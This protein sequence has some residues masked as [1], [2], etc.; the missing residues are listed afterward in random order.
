[1]GKRGPGLVRRKG[2]MGSHSRKDEYMMAPEGRWN[3]GKQQKQKGK[4]F[5]KDE[6]QRFMQHVEDLGAR[7][8]IMESDGNCLFRALADQ[9]RGRPEDHGEIRQ[10]VIDFIEAHETDFAPF[11]EDDEKLSDYVHRMRNEGEWGAFVH[12]MIPAG[13]EILPSPFW[14]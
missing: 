8:L 7:I 3:G 5:D 9:L 14:L 13:W 6:E 2:N 1:M 11:V 4:R 10:N 12:G